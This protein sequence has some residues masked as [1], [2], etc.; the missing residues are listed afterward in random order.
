MT[1]RR[2]GTSAGNSE[3]RAATGASVAPEV[4]LFS[5]RVRV[6]DFIFRFCQFFISF[7]L[8]LYWCTV[9]DPVGTDLIPR[10]DGCDDRAE[11][12]TPADFGTIVL[13]FT[14]D[15]ASRPQAAESPHRQEEQP[16]AS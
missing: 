9:N 5:Y 7:S 13:P 4:Q 10:G 3:R 14:P 1:T 8:F 15:L 6:A 11:I 2:V 12:Y 16:E